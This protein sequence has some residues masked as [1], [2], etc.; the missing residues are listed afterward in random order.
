[1]EE[2]GVCCRNVYSDGLQ[3]LARAAVA[4]DERALDLFS[5]WRPKGFPWIVYYNCSY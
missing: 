3:E 1:M 4:G 5:T 2:A